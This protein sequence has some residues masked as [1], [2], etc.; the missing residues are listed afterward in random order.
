ME[1]LLPR[2][3][4]GFFLV[5]NGWTG[6]GVRTHQGSSEVQTFYTLDFESRSRVAS[7]NSDDS[8]TN[9][10]RHAAMLF[11]NDNIILGFEDLNRVNRSANHLQIHI[12]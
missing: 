4:A 6:S 12:G 2:A 11:A 5:Q 9:T 8:A 7:N 10:S 3:P 1:H